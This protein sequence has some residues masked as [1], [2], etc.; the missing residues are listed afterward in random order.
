MMRVII[1][2]GIAVFAAVV[3]AAPQQV[4]GEA[5]PSLIGDVP[6]EVADIPADPVI[7]EPIR[8]LFPGGTDNIVRARDCGSPEVL[9]MSAGAWLL[10]MLNVASNPGRARRGP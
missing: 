1:L 4:V 10:L 5:I 6:P 7:L 3:L 8:P 9:M 2:C